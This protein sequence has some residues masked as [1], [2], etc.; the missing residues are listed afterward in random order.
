[1]IKRTEIL[2]FQSLIVG[3]A[4]IL[5]VLYNIVVKPLIHIQKSVRVYRDDKDSDRIVK[6]M[7][8]IYSENEIGILSDDLSDL[9]IE[10]Q[11]YAGEMEKMTRHKERMNAEL[12]VAERI[13]SHML[14]K[15]D[16]AFP[17]RDDFR[18]YAAYKPA[19]RVG[20]DF[21][22]FFF[23]DDRHLVL[24]MGDVSGKGIPASLFMVITK[25]L[26]MER[27]LNSNNLNPGEILEDVNALLIRNNPDLM[28]VTVWLGILNVSTG[29]LRS[30]NAGHE[31]PLI[32]RKGEDFAVKTEERG[33]ALGIYEK[34]QYD[35]EKNSCI[36]R[37]GDRLFVYTDGVTDAADKAEWRF[38]QER[39]E[40]C[41]NGYSGNDVADVLP[42]IQKAI[43]DF[44][45]GVEQF[46]DITMMIVEL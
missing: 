2:T 16:P 7:G 4:V 31:F 24:V 1:M 29:E 25:N 43:D 39:L 8:K 28:F 42:G 40:K 44:A 30:A 10:L 11:R 32:C 45:S 18:L 41:L 19:R 3:A 38:G 5:L 17:E 35:Y 6:A 21:Y 9:A 34:G 13:Q 26:I 23:A 20:G 46:D 36:L 27:A 37:R 33:I 15:A 14:P 22:D 12:S